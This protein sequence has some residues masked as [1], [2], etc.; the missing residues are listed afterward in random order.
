M[1][2]DD[3]PSS[4]LVSKDAEATSSS[5]TF[6]PKNT[7]TEQSTTTKSQHENDTLD[8]PRR[9][10]RQKVI[11]DYRT[12]NDPWADEQND[13]LTSAEMIYL[14]FNKTKLA[15]EFPKSL[16][17]AK[18]SSAWPDWEKAVHTE[19]QQLHRMGTWQLVNPPPNLQ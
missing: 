3:N 19:L 15:P 12:L 18:Q 10:T 14:T 6:T 4:L 9:S 8:S 2:N 1:P 16:K 11:H 13:R 17:E 5:N 7:C